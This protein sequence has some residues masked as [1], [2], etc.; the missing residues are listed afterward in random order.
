M[1]SGRGRQSWE[2]NIE[3]QKTYTEVHC[4]TVCYGLD[5]L[6]KTYVEIELPLW[7]YWEVGPLRSDEVK[8]ASSS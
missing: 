1:V 8:E 6:A 2:G 4:I 7:R 5:V 3:S